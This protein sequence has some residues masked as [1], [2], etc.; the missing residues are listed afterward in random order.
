MR[1]AEIRALLEYLYW[2]R[3]RVLSA[4]SQAEPDADLR[5]KLVHELDVE[6]G[7]RARLLGA[8]EIDLD[9]ANFPTIDAIADHWQRDEHEMW[10]WIATLTDHALAGPSAHEANQVF[11]LWYY[12]VHVVCHGIQELEEAVVLLGPS[13]H[14]PRDLGF[15]DYADTTVDRDATSAGA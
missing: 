5:A 13:G 14:S 11:P 6:S 10:A 7:W 2:I 8:E 9:P 3:D 4:A 12:L 15:L 1:G